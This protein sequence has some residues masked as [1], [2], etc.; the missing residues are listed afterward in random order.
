MDSSVILPFVDVVLVLSVEVGYAWPDRDMLVLVYRVSAMLRNEE[1]SDRAAEG[2]NVDFARYL[3]D[4]IPLPLSCVDKVA[5]RERYVSVVI[6]C[7]LGEYNVPP[8]S[9]EV[10]A[11]HG[12]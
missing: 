7:V 3:N 1:V 10:S 8:S 4:D 9:V 2:P 5:D 11:C 12:E 6:S